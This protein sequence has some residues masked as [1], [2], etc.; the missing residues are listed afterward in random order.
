VRRSTSRALRPA[1][2]CGSTVSGGQTPA[3]LG[4]APGSHVLTLRHPNAI[5]GVLS[6]DVPAE[7]TDLTV[8]LWRRQPDILPLRPVYPAGGKSRRCRFLADRTV[9]LS[10]SP[11]GGSSA[12]QRQ[13]ARE[14][15][16][17]DPATGSLARLPAQFLWRR[18]RP[19]ARHPCSARPSE[20]DPSQQ[21]AASCLAEA[22]RRSPVACALHWK[23]APGTWETQ[24]RSKSRRDSR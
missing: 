5:S 9:A 2:R 8:S 16:H 24:P 15:W 17:L 10:V 14:L 7:G 3:T 19:V 6:I 11:P 13:R 23:A 21:P 4:L 18:A 20:L 1:Q 12:A 22:R